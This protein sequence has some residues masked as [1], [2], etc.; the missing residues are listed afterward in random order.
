MHSSGLGPGILSNSM[1]PAVFLDRDNTLI[2]NDGDL[3]DP[4][5]VVLL[6]GVA[7]GLRRLDQAGYRLVVITNQ[8][9]VARGRYAEADVDA[10][11]Q[12]VQSLLG[13]PPALSFYY[14]PFHPKGTVSKY[15]REHPWRKPA[16]G[17]L[18]EAAERE[19]ITLEASWMIG[20]QPRD[21][22]A[23][24]AAGC[25]AIL[26]GDHDEPIDARVV[27]VETFTQAVE[28]VLEREAER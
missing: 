21:A 4:D 26:L 15:T 1:Q 9:G 19:H 11:H 2:A 28:L 10:V 8:G 22:E 25:R 13:P 14:C 24:L 23:G 27:R 7:E 6:E 18:L 16:P 12:R 5:A 20:D 17:M 3:G